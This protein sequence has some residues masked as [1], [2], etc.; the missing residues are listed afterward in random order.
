MSAHNRY[1]H[2]FTLTLSSVSCRN[3]G[4][5][6]RMMKS[7]RNRVGSVIA[8]IMTSDDGIGWVGTWTHGHVCLMRHVSSRSGEACSRT[9]ILRLLTFLSSTLLG[10]R[11]YYPHSNL[12][13]IDPEH[14][15]DV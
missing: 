9:A 4:P 6:S 5:N 3:G 1:M 13:E 10:R 11:G 2:I 12:V 14:I 15:P 8:D 7:L